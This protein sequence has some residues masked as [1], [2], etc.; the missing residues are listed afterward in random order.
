[1]NINE[2]LDYT[3]VKTVRDYATIKQRMTLPKALRSIIQSESYALPNSE[4]LSIE[5]I[6][7]LASGSPGLPDSRRGVLVIPVM[8][9]DNDGVLSKVLPG[10]VPVIEV[11]R[12]V[13]DLDELGEML[14]NL[15]VIADLVVVSRESTEVASKSVQGS[16]PLLKDDGLDF[17][18]ADG[19]NNDPESDPSVK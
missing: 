19:L 11:E 17:D 18:F 7:A 5:I 13:L 3:R 14:N 8:S 10:E 12:A 9:L 1:M 4:P 15:L 16:V 2:V 6:P